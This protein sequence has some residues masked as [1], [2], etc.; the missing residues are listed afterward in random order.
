MGKKI[1]IPGS[2]KNCIM[3]SGS[4]VAEQEELENTRVWGGP[5]SFPWSV[6]WLHS[7]PESANNQ[8]ILLTPLPTGTGELDQP[9]LDQPTERFHPSCI[10]SGTCSFLVLKL[11]VCLLSLESLAYFNG[12][13]V[14]YDKYLAFELAFF[15]VL[16]ATVK[17]CGSLLFSLRHLPKPPSPKWFS[18]PPPILSPYWNLPL[19]EISYFYFY[20]SCSFF[21]H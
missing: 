1:I 5:V 17:P 20:T 9:D 14:N 4:P 19:S 2:A 18:N 13:P 6:H 8:P 15:K 21:L 7:Y 11:N 16:W 3:Q 12:R 10:I